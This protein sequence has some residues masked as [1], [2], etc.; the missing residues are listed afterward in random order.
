M[1]NNKRRVSVYIDGFNLYHALDD[2]NYTFKKRK[3]IGLKPADQRLNHYKW[4]DLKTLSQNLMR[5]YQELVS[6]KYYSA[7]ANH[8][9]QDVVKRHRAYVQALE[10]SG[11]EV[12][13][14]VFKRSQ[15]GCRNCGVR[16]W[17][18]EEKESDVRIATDIV[19]DALRDNFDDA[20]IISAD[21]DMKP[22]KEHVAQVA[23]DK[24]I[25]V[26]A[27]PGRFAHARDLEPVLEATKGRVGK[28]LLPETITNDAGDV[29]VTRPSEYDP[30]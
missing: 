22:A 20:M 29:V 23:G 30:P 6:V 26:I 13:L 1:K 16:W 19:A 8:R 4:L 3:K 12:T 7:Y 18:Y 5:D 2:L 24:N 25:F 27:P 17:K 28:S 10:H 15:Q 11:V 14:G 21:S 9:G